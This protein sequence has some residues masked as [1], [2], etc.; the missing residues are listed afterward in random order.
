MWPFDELSLATPALMAALKEESGQN[1]GR[2]SVTLIARFII[3]WTAAI[4][5][6]MKAVNG[7]E[8]SP[9]PV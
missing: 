4:C 1:D 6:Y 9:G 5:S 3:Q 2:A 8:T 7:D